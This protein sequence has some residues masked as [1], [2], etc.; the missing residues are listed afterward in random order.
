MPEITLTSDKE[1]EIMEKILKYV[2]AEGD[3]LA[4]RRCGGLIIQMGAYAVEIKSVG[5]VIKVRLGE[6]FVCILSDPDFSLIMLKINELV[7][8]RYNRQEKRRR[9]EFLKGLDL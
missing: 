4:V 2:E 3:R 6:D 8:E 1:T 5:R 9:E 7:R